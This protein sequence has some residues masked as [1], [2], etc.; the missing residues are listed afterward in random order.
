MGT[1]NFC[2]ILDYSAFPGNDH[3]DSS[4]CT[5]CQINPCLNGGTC[6]GGNKQ[7]FE[8]QC[9]LGKGGEFCTEPVPTCPAVQAGGLTWP[10]TNAGVVA[11]QS[12]WEGYSGRIEKRC[13][14]DG[15]WRPHI[16]YCS[17]NSCPAETAANALW[18]L[19]LSLSTADGS[20]L[21]GYTGTPSRDCNASGEWGPVADGCIAESGGQVT[22]PA[23]SSGGYEWEETP[24]LSN[25][26]LPCADGGQGGVFRFCD[27]QGNW[28]G[29]VDECEESAAAALA[30]SLFYLSLLVALFLGR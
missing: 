20:C 11:E 30:P 23:E 10:E 24:A 9:T 3:P 21:P 15:E 2:P 27:A 4:N 25:G 29:I 12:C 22:C 8:C 7:L 6:K 16:T 26:S 18:N 1:N 19:T 28:Q 13:Q 14:E 17:R 5:S